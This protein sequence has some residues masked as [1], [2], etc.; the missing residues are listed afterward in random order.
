MIEL[1]R[2][3]RFFHHESGSRICAL[4]NVSIRIDTG[5][6]VCVT[7]A[8]GTGK[9]TLINILGGLDRPSRG[10]YRLAG[11]DLATLKEEGLALLRRDAFGFVF[12][13]QNLL[14][15]LT[16]L[17]NVELRGLYAGLERDFRR[18]RA[19]NL[20]AALGLSDRVQHYPTELSGGEQQRVSIARALMHG[21]IILADEPTGALDAEN[22]ER[23]LRILE[24]LPRLG[25]T[26][27][28]VSHN[29]AIAVRA[30]R[31]IQLHKGRVI[32]DDGPTCSTVSSPEASPAKQPA[33][34]R[35]SSGI[36]EALRA[37]W[38]SFR[39]NLRS[40][41]R[42][43]T[44]L[45]LSSIL[46]SVWFGATALSLGEGTY[47][48]TIN[49]VNRMGLDAITV[50]PFNALTGQRGTLTLEDIA[51]IEETVPN[52][53]GVSPSIYRPDVSVRFGDAVASVVVEGFVDIGSVADRGTAAWRLDRGAFIT[54]RE[55]DNLE[56]V[57]VISSEVREQLFPTAIDPIGQQ[58]FI[59][60][61][62]FRIKGVLKRRSGMGVSA[63]SA[64]VQE[65]LERRLNSRVFIPFQT[66]AALLFG[67]RELNRA[68]VFL[69]DPQKLFEAADDVRDVLLRRYES[70]NFTIEHAGEG[71]RNAD[72]LRKRLW[73]GLGG[74]AGIALLAGGLGVMALM[75]SFVSIRAREIG[76]RLAMGAR[77]Q[78]IRQQFLCESALTAVAGGLLGAIASVACFPAYRFFDLPVA[79]SGRFVAIPFV[80]AVVV[81]SA[82]GIS[83]AYRASR[84]DPAAALAE[85]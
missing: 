76:I 58:V 50:F 27:I 52:V 19:L 35:T 25:H 70:E 63:I 60:N 18:K 41:Q 8:S 29:P 15:S 7:G 34:L 40:G 80:C 6:Y 71:I 61:Q 10:I 67:S 22:S 33:K 79:L 74:A 53:R 17:E 55:D 66:G 56:Q 38:L 43:R 32:G 65:E 20:L 51:A 39:T 9:T 12:Q 37:G 62:P 81:G 1:Q 14:E 42:L 24:R 30:L 5:E 68:T 2:V 3:S 4:Q 36:L 69:H 11:Q 13:S 48:Q 26:L 21:R 83:A 82:F 75:I 31:R 73:L 77:R 23:V 28:M 44:T 57:A 84:V 85:D 47:R 54:K 49:A 46:V 72:L 78:N 16:V 45:I 59:G 64:D